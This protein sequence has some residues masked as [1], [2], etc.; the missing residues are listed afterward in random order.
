MS[1]TSESCIRPVLRADA[2]LEVRPGVI[3]LAM[4]NDVYT[5]AT[6]EVTSLAEALYSM[7]GQNDLSSICLRT[8]TSLE[9]ASIVVNRLVSLGALHIIQEAD[10]VL[11][12][13]AEFAAISRELYATWKERL[14][15]H[16]LWC[17]L[18]E[19]SLPHQVFVGWV[20]ESYWFILGVLER[21]PMAVAHCEDRIGRSIFSKHFSEEWD[22]YI[23]FEQSLDKL[24]VDETAR[25]EME[26]LPA[27]RAVQ[28]WMRMAARRD[29]LQ[30]VLCSGFLEST[31][32]DR[33]NARSFF[34]QV[35]RNYLSLDND[36]VTP[37]IEHVS[38][39]EAYGH[40]GIVELFLKQNETVDRRRARCA[41]Q[42][43]YGFVET[44]EM[45]STD[46]LRHYLTEAPK[47]SA[48]RPYRSKHK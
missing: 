8:G 9:I 36:A 27:T 21:L 20:V 19:G 7:N 6:S 18:V 37:M 43:A 41:L 34:D 3:E 45:W 26:P 13:S 4:G 39:D 40:G 5:I 23:F 28:N 33:T 29:P 25:A 11:V 15:S 30:Y 12:D 47:P 46:I 24:G 1:I 22:H 31:G 32:S 2:S 16:Q 48:S 35:A 14:F 42:S 44:L 17:G 38:L 10:S